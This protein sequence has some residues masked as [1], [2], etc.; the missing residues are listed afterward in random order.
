MNRRSLIKKAGVAATGVAGLGIAGSQ[1]A[2]AEPEAE[3][4]APSGPVPAE[5][6]VAFVR[7][8]RRGEVT[9]VAGTEETTYRDPALVARMTRAAGSKEVR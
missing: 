6:V 7:D 1:A 4:V 3:V 2:E 5:P 9:V 8:A